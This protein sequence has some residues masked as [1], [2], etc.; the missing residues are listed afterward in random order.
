LD[1]LYIFREFVWIVVFLFIFVHSVFLVWV[2]MFWI[3]WELVWISFFFSF[4]FKF[5][6]VW[7]FLSVSFYQFFFFLKFSLTL[8][9]ISRVYFKTSYPLPSNR[10]FIFSSVAWL[11]YLVRLPDLFY[12]PIFAIKFRLCY[13]SHSFSWSKY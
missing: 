11:S 4:L 1:L 3:F 9:L 12:P 13:P 5:C 7:H 8:W 6:S 10:F 2:L